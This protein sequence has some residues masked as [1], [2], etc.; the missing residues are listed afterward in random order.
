MVFM[1]DE[2]EGIMAEK[3]EI[4]SDKEEDD[5]GMGEIV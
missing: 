5:S 3:D 4:E 2:R 1:E